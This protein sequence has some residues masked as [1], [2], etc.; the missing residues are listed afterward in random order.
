M[1]NIDPNQTQWI[2][3]LGPA[4]EGNSYGTDG[5][6]VANTPL[7]E[8][9]AEAQRRY[10]MALNYTPA[11]YQAALAREA[12]Y[13]TPGGVGGFGG[14]MN[15]NLNAANLSQYI[16]PINRYVGPLVL[17]TVMAIGGGLVGGG[18]AGAATAGTALAGTTAGS[19]IAGAGSGAGSAAFNTI[20]QIDQGNVGDALLGLAG[21]TIMG[22]IGGAALGS[23]PSA[24]TMS[25]ADVNTLANGAY[26]A[27][28]L[29]VDPTLA[30]SG[31]MSP[32]SI[33]N[34]PIT[35]AFSVDPT[36]ANGLMSP[37]LSPDVIPAPTYSNALTPTPEFQVNPALSPEAPAFNVNPELHAFSNT[38]PEYNPN[39]NQSTNTKPLTDAVTKMA[40]GLLGG[41][42]ASMSM[43]TFNV[44][45]TPL[46]QQAFGTTGNNWMGA[47][48]LRAAGATGNGLSQTPF[49]GSFLANAADDK[50]ITDYLADYLPLNASKK[51][52]DFSSFVA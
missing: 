23:T 12:S 46:S 37:S 51:L 22:G 42:N 21:S 1:A 52:K 29:T 39:Y 17:P 19:A 49:K 8:A 27:P 41:N 48:K 50:R 18:L 24:P 11:E 13:L 30:P 45:Y 15:Q 38:L 47:D 7:G 32:G 36:L 25:T 33:G 35:P 4:P 6:L 28:T 16:E 9:E 43:P 2:T 31:L 44:N 40:K 34:V 5:S 10:Q 14:F 20:N 26:A 3:A